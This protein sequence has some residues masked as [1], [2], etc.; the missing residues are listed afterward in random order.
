MATLAEQLANRQRILASRPPAGI[1]ATD[2]DVLKAYQAQMSYNNQADV[3]TAALQRKLVDDLNLNKKNRTL[4]ILN[5]HTG[6]SDRGL[7]NSGAAL[8]NDAN[9]DTNFD[10]SDRGLNDN[11]TNN[12]GEIAR[13]KLGY[14]QDYQNAQVG[15]SAKQTKAAADAAAAALA[16]RQQAEQ[17]RQQQADLL[18]AMNPAPVEAAP[19]QTYLPP[20]I[21]KPPPVPT[22]KKVVAAVAKKTQPK[23]IRYGGPQ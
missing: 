4:S 1:M 22:I 11:L 23:L 10:T 3:D 20:S 18:A 16:A 2:P 7:L 8:T 9:I 15:A 6:L 12:L 21:Y 13:R 5:A 19:T 17:V 14:Y